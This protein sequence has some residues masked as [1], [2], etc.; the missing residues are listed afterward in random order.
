MR[1]SRR[2]LQGVK[3]LSLRRHHSRN[4]QSVTAWDVPFKL[5]LGFRLGPSAGKPYKDSTASGV[6]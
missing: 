6:C 5:T 3:E 4:T 1:F 2:I